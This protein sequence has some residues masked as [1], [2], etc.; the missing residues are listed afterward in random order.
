MATAATAAA[1]LCGRSDEEFDAKLAVLLPKIGGD[2]GDGD[3]DMDDMDAAEWSRRMRLLFSPLEMLNMRAP[4][5][6]EDAPEGAGSEEFLEGALDPDYFTGS[7]RFVDPATGQLVEM[8]G[9]SESHHGGNLQYYADST[10]WTAGEHTALISALETIGCGLWDE[11]REKAEG[12]A[13]REFAPAEIRW[14]VR[15]P[16]PRRIVFFVMRFSLFPLFRESHTQHLGSVPT[17]W[18]D[19]T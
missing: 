14:K 11:I 13:L 3:N 6:D 1:P 7:A 2:G 17:S 19:S 10:K 18:G 5:G 16:R 12:G 15:L 9:S 8:Q 4:A